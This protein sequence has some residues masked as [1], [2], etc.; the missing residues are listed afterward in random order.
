MYENSPL[1]FMKGGLFSFPS[2]GFVV[3]YSLPRQHVII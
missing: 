1:L 2:C 3:D